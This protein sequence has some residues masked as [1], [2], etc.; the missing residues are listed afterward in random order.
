MYIDVHGEAS[1]VFEGKSVV[2]DELG[3]IGLVK[4]TNTVNATTG[5]TLFSGITLFAEVVNGVVAVKIE[6]PVE[7]PSGD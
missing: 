6:T 2:S 7:T 1:K 5:S 4:D 3:L